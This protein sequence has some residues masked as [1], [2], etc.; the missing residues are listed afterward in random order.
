M[1][2]HASKIVTAYVRAN[3]VP[4]LEIP[5]LITKVVNALERAAAPVEVAPEL[6]P[7][8]AVKKSVTP[9]AVICLECGAHQ[10]TLKRHL[11]TAHDLSPEEYRG[12]WGLS[13]DYPMVAPNYAAK[14]SQLA[15]DAGLGRKPDE[16]TGEDD[17]VKPFRY[18]TNRWSKP[19]K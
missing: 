4:V 19:T 15:K 3:P 6:A 14:R 18:P 13:S 5:A 2:K 7:A 9:E 12:R 8:V 1:L 16:Q 10:K 11:H 17:A